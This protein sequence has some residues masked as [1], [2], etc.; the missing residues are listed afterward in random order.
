MI[1]TITAVLP[2]MGTLMICTSASAQTSSLDELSAF[3]ERICR[4]VPLETHTTKTELS[5]EAKAELS[6]FLKRLADIGGEVKGSRIDT[7][8]T[9]V[10][11]DQ[12]AGIIANSNNCRQ[13][14]VHDFKDIVLKPAPRPEP[15][16]PPPNGDTGTAKRIGYGP[17]AIGDTIDAIRKSGIPGRFGTAP[18]GSMQFLID[19]KISIPTGQN[20]SINQQG[21]IVYWL[22]HGTVD[23][24]VVFVSQRGTCEQVD[25][26]EPLRSQTI[27][28]MGEPIE[29]PLHSHGTAPVFG[30]P[31]TSND[32]TEYRFQNGEEQRT[33][34]SI[35]AT[36]PTN[37][38]QQGCFVSV[39][40]TKS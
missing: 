26:V 18:D 20:S 17:F 31:T 13:A 5:G 4:D 38:S 2:F 12:L 34:G 28:E 10:L 14:V 32:I 30:G 29:G 22:N 6:N 21:G 23:R 3:A 15:V 16:P 27:R 8:T 33:F 39:V 40:Y 37:M 24:V 35:T 9:G 11:Q 19:T 1:R 25:W 36:L 7:T